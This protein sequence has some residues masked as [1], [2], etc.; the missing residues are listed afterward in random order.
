MFFTRQK[1]RQG[2]TLIELLIVVAIIAIL[3]AIAVPNFLE[4]QTRSKVA[5][6][7]SDMR[8]LATAIEAYLVDNNS[9]PC[10]GY[11]GTYQTW[12]SIPTDVTSDAEYDARHLAPGGLIALTTPVVFISTVPKDVFAKS[13]G[14]HGWGGDIDNP[15]GRGITATAC[16][17]QF[18]SGID[19]IGDKEVSSTG[20]T[21]V[22]KPR[23][24][25][26]LVSYG[27]D[28]VL[29]TVSVQYDG[30]T[31]TACWPVRHDM[32]GEYIGTTV[33][34]IGDP[35]GG[36][37]GNLDNSDPNRVAANFTETNPWLSGEA[38]FVGTDQDIDDSNPASWED[39]ESAAWRGINYDS[40][41]GSIS[42]GDIYHWTS[43]DVTAGF[44][45]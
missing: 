2:F 24:F 32:T 30:T 45:K 44:K 4:A 11:R 6:V 39:D 9:Y 17:F 26:M 33:D 13:T 12:G 40:T 8:S 20:F 21:L 34:D 18:Y 31:T 35:N 37:H 41:N 42:D 16:P 19:E 25:W 5:R 1:G 28:A 27:P 10:S 14:L 22:T 38:F 7:K 43:G 3:A 23:R 36:N 29:N 15:T